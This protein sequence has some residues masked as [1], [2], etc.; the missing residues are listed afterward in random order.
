[1]NVTL[2]R[3]QDEGTEAI[4][5]VASLKHL[6]SID[7]KY[8]LECWRIRIAREIILIQAE[9]QKIADEACL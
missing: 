3:L 1:M 5:Q 7:R 9:E 2:S 6:P 4:D 8:I